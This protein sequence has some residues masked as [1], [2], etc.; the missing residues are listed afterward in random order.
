MVCRNPLRMETTGA[1]CKMVKI[2]G[3]FLHQ[4]IIVTIQP[5]PARLGLPHLALPGLT[6]TSQALV[7][8]PSTAKTL[9]LDN[10]T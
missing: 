9:A 1:V 6:Q 10:K 3:V 2:W 8:S 7:A 5:S 4:A